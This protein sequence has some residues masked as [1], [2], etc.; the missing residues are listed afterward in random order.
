MASNN[1][2]NAEYI[3]RVAH[4]QVLDLLD[5]NYR[6]ACNAKKVPIPDGFAMKEYVERVLTECGFGEKRARNLAIE[7]FLTLMLAFTKANIHFA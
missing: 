3:K 7:D 5:R 4:F 6:T 1:F 2:R